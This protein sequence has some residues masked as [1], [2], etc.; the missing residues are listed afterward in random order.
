MYRFTKLPEGLQV[1]NLGGFDFV[2]L[3]GSYGWEESDST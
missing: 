1:E 3:I 2:P